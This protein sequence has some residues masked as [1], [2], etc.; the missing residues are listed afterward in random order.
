MSQNNDKR[1][2]RKKTNTVL[3]KY[4]FK[5]TRIITFTSTHRALDDLKFY[6]VNRVDRRPWWD[7]AGKFGLIKFTMKDKKARRLESIFKKQ[8]KSIEITIIGF[9]LNKNFLVIDGNHRLAALIRSK[10]KDFRLKVFLITGR[11]SLLDRVSPDYF[12]FRRFLYR[13]G[14]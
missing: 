12:T 11:K 10:R 9:L 14:R 4:Y 7:N 8:K 13:R 1:F 6:G 3:S 2:I 5:K